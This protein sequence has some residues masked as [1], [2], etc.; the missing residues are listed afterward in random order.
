MQEADVSYFIILH[1]YTSLAQHCCCGLIHVW[2]WTA[3]SL[4]QHCIDLFSLGAKVDH[5]S[6]N[7]HFVY[8]LICSENSWIDINKMFTKC[9]YVYSLFLCGL[10]TV[11]IQSDFEILFMVFI[12]IEQKCLF[13][14]YSSTTSE[15]FT[16][17]EFRVW[18]IIY[19][20]LFT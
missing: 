20:P 7:A 2:A 18:Y 9:F 6:M 17:A 11:W 10:K 1:Y 12:G 16:S 19:T 5:E 14:L 13:C 8:V 15:D 3:T 4:R